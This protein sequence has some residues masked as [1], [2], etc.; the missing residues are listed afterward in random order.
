MGSGVATA[1]T[2]AVLVRMHADQEESGHLIVYQPEKKKYIPLSRREEKI[3]REPTFF[4]SPRIKTGNIFKLSET[5]NCAL[6]PAPAA[7]MLAL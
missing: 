2:S 6:A 5:A 4:N 7:V 3:H 1:E